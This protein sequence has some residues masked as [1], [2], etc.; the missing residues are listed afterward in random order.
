MTAAS[1]RSLAGVIHIHCHSGPDSLP[2]TLD[3]VDLALIAKES[4][5]AWH[6][7]QKPL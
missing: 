3:A 7:P 2:R 5:Y 4:W 1:D 6:C